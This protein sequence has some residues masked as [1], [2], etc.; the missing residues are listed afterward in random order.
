MFDEYNVPVELKLA[1]SADFLWLM[2]ESAAVADYG[3]IWLHEN[4]L[5]LQVRTFTFI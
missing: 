2:S 5:N 1:P 4:L 3:K